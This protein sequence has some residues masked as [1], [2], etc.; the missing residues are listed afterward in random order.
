MGDAYGAAIIEAT[1]KKE[2]DSLP[3]FEADK[4]EE[5]NNVTD[6]TVTKL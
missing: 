5:S 2:L 4:K 1:S 6:Q 3:L